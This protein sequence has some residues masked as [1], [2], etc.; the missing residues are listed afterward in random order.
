M[1]C[2]DEA[3]LVFLQDDWIFFQTLKTGYRIDFKLII[4]D[5]PAQLRN[6]VFVTGKVRIET[7]GRRR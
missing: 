4:L 3:G 5:E 1:R 7:A 6:G 2:G